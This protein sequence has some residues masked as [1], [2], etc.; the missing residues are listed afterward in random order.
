MENPGPGY[1]QAP[2][3][4]G[5]YDGDIYKQFRESKRSKNGWTVA[6]DRVSYKWYS[7]IILKVTVIYWNF[8]N[9]KNYFGYFSL[10]NVKRIFLTKS[11]E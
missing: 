11:S 10:L 7:L 5:L 2:S 9:N 4:F 1:Y 3:E 6:T 8:S